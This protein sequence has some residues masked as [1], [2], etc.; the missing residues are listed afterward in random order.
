V[1]ATRPTPPLQSYTPARTQRPSETSQRKAPA[2]VTI[3]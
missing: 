1:N 3:W 2:E